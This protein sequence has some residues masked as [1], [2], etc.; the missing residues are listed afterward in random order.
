MKRSLLVCLI[1]LLCPSLAFSQVRLKELAHVQGV[2]DNQLIGYGLVVGLNKTG[3]RCQTIFST[4]SLINMLQRMAVTVTSN[5]IRVETIAAVFVTAT[6]SPF[7][8]G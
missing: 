1:L 6:L 5:D 2:R 8:R 7:V 4:Q 3:D